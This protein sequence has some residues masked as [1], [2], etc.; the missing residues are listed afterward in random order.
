MCQ[1]GADRRGICGNCLGPEDID[2]ARERIGPELLLHHG[3]Q[4][5]HALAEPRRHQDPHLAPRDD[6]A[7]LQLCP[8]VAASLSADT[9]IAPPYSTSIDAEFTTT[10]AKLSRSLAVTDRP[11]ACR[12]QAN[13]CGGVSHDGYRTYR[14]IAAQTGED[15][16][17]ARRLRYRLNHCL[18]IGPI[19]MSS[20]SDTPSTCHF[21]AGTAFGGFRATFSAWSLASIADTISSISCR[22]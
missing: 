4:S 13:N 12:R 21:R 9:R 14:R 10:D 7:S 18:R 20:P 22:L 1:R 5:I 11:R 8:T 15:L 6:H 3:G 2:S 16:Q 17:P 19:P